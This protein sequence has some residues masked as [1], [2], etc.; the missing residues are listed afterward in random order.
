MLGSNVYLRKPHALSRV[1]YMRSLRTSQ[2]AT[3]A[4]ALTADTILRS[5]DVVL[6][7]HVSD[8]LLQIPVLA[9]IQLRNQ[10]SVLLEI[11]RFRQA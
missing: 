4:Q 8:D 2:L 11:L 6:F 5:Q 7:P 3:E 1:L 9:V 10:V